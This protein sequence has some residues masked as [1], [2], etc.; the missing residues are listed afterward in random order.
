MKQI[1]MSAHRG[2]ISTG[3]SDVTNFTDGALLGL[4]GVPVDFV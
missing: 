2:G 4:K 3:K 1:N